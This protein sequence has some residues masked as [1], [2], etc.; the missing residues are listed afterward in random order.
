MPNHI[1][2]TLEIRVWHDEHKDSIDKVLKLLRGDGEQEVIDFA[3]IVP[4]PGSLFTDNLGSKERE[5]CARTG[6]PN[7]Y[8]WQIENWGTKWNA[9]DE[10][11]VERDDHN[12]VIQFDTA[13]S[14]PEPVIERLRE[15]IADM[16]S[17]E[18]GYETDVA[19]HWVEEGHQSAGVF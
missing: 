11:V 17:Y 16:F 12:V 8:D 13:W 9:Y 2:N 4:Q 7:W 18:D 19:G 10:S 5:E 14:P 15:M 3:A 6:R 1:T